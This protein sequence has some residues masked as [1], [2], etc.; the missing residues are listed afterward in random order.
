MATSLGEEKVMDGLMDSL[1]VCHEPEIDYAK[2]PGDRTLD[3]GLLGHFPK[4]GVFRRF[5]RLNVTFWE[6]PEGAPALVPAPNQEA[7]VSI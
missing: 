4:R 2:R 6:R 5:A 3:A 1:S 7:G